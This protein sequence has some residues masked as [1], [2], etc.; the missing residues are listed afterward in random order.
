[1][2]I[3]NIVKRFPLSK[4]GFHIYDPLKG[5]DLVCSANTNFSGYSRDTSIR[6]YDAVHGC[7][8]PPRFYSSLRELLAALPSTIFRIDI[9]NH[10]GEV[11]KRYYHV[12]NTFSSLS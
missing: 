8:G 10:D 11:V 5:L 6:C 4:H 2:R 7:H 9:L 1:M 3:E 12:K